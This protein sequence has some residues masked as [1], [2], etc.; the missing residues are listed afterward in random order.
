MP[1]PRGP[2]PPLA[3]CARGYH[4]H[5]DVTAYV[6][7]LNLGSARTMVVRDVE[8]RTGIFKSPRQGPQRLE[9]L[10]FI[11]D[12]RVTPRK[13]GELDHAVHAYPGEHYAWWAARF[14]E[15]PFVPG[16][17][18]ENLT[19][20]GA[21]ET[22][23]C[24]GDVVACGTSRL[25]VSQ[26]RIPCRRLT[27][28]V[29]IEGFSRLF[30]ES[31]RVGYYLRVEEPGSLQVSD[32]FEV[33]D[34]DPSSPTV[35]EFVRISQLDYWDADGLDRLL[36]ARGLSAIWRSILEDKRSRA[37]AEAERGGWFGTRTLRVVARDEGTISLA[38]AQGGELPAAR[39]GQELMMVVAESGPHGPRT[40]R[41]LLVDGG[42][43]APYRVAH[44][45]EPLAAVA[46]GDAV[47]CHAPR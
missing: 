1:P 4:D 39:E 16:G 31:T 6:E 20:R 32:A 45:A 15:G 37:R 21:L 12:E 14:G 33:V 38:C 40:T 5:A 44:D 46:V 9:A 3:T 22:E 47:R 36:L 7:S 35:A 19:V 23:V 30:L 41:A 29:G 8:V 27:A 10:G 11:G 34:R 25:V 13:L 42:L 28:R 43:G 24:I 18:G 26:P 2:H 17:F